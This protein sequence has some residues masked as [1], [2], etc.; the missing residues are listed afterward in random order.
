MIKAVIFDFDGTVSNRMA[1]AYNVFN[2]YF[3]QY[4]LD[5]TDMEF[6]AILQDMVTFDCNGTT[7]VEYRLIPFIKKYEDHL[8]KDFSEKFTEFYYEYMWKHCVLKDEADGVL[9]KLKE[10]YRLA[11][12]SNG[13][14]K[15][16]HDKINY[17]G[18]DKYFEEIIVSGDYGINKPD[19]RIFEIMAEKLGLK[20][21]ECAF[22][23]DVFSSDILGAIRANMVPIWL[24]SDYEKQNYYYK[25]IRIEKLSQIFDVL[26]NLNK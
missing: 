13:Q 11:L 6:E 24:C 19:P 9:T 4:F 3:R 25:G 20:C 2:E 18:C 23:G 7:K 26:D 5:K 15:S 22:I 8:P 10:K 12:L 17:V 1:N 21:E 14:S 16:Q